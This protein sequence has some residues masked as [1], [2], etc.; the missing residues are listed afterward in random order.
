MGSLRYIDV[1]MR[2]FL[3][4]LLLTPLSLFSQGNRFSLYLANKTEGGYVADNSLVLTDQIFLMKQT[5]STIT[6]TSPALVVECFGDSTDIFFNE[7]FVDRY[8]TVLWKDPH[9]YIIRFTQTNS[10]YYFYEIF[11]F[12]NR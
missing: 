9:Y 6:F 3:F 5:D 1:I 10:Y 4:I 8:P 11:P 12:M 7:V 2:F